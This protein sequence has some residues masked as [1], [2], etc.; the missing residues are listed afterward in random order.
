[1]QIYL[2]QRLTWNTSVGGFNQ[3]CGAGYQATLDDWS[4]SRIWSR[5]RSHKSCAEPEQRRFFLFHYRSTL[6][7]CIVVACHFSTHAARLD[8]SNASRICSTHPQRTMR[9][10]ETYL[11]LVAQAEAVEP[12]SKT[13]RRL[14]P[15]PEISRSTDL[16]TMHATNC[17]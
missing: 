14:G 7:E 9:R 17:L 8:V 12:E 4:W 13:F 5:I 11:K 3:V 15:E 1:M 6:T 10:V 16:A 2:E